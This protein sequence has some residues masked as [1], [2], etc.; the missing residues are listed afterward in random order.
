MVE[1]NVPLAHGNS[2]GPLAD[3]LGRVIG[4]DAAEVVG[5]KAAV[6]LPSDLVIRI[7]KRLVAT[8]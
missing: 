4:I 1:S 5:E 8:E 7:V 3:A 2:G 6:T